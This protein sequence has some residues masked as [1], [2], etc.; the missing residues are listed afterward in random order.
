MQF[1]GVCKMSWTHLMVLTLMN[2]RVEGETRNQTSISGIRCLSP[3]QDNVC[4]RQCALFPRNK[5]SPPRKLTSIKICKSWHHYRIT[6]CT[7]SSIHSFTRSSPHINYSK[8]QEMWLDNQV[9]LYLSSISWW[10]CSIILLVASSWWRI[11]NFMKVLKFK[12]GHSCSNA[13][14]RSQ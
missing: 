3:E 9:T 5:S 12:F 4:R 1:S 14:W 8:G 10:W 2:E 11:T 6:I 13:C 7:M